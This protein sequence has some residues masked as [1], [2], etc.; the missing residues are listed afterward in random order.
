M[1]NIKYIYQHAG[2]CG[3]QQNL[4]DILGVS[5]VSNPEEITYDSPSLH[6]TQTTLKTSA[7]KSLCLFTNIFDVKNKIAKLRI[8]AAKSKR[9]SRKFG[10]S[11]WTNKIK[12]KVHSKISY[13]IKR[14][15][16]RTTWGWRVIHS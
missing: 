10:N 13:Q 2:K 15:L 12:L 3:D 5:M 11:L 4:K 9:R 7:S 16:Y 6:M 8:E 1:N 14:N